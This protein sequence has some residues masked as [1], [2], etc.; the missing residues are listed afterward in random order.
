MTTISNVRL[1]LLW[2]R[3]HTHIHTP[4]HHHTHTHTTPRHNTHTQMTHTH[5][6]THTQTHATQA[7]AHTTHTHTRTHAHSLSRLVEPRQAPFEITNSPALLAS[8]ISLECWSS[9]TRIVNLAASRARATWAWFRP[10]ASC[11]AFCSDAPE[12]FGAASTE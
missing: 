9:A 10:A 7:A 11:V 1:L 12:A 4:H 2:P 8:C 5:T 3:P 6:H